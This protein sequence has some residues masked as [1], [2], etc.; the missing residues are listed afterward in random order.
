MIDH[1]FVVYLAKQVEKQNAIEGITYKSIIT[2]SKN[3]DDTCFFQERLNYLDVKTSDAYVIDHRL[4]YQRTL[5][6]Q[7][8]LDQV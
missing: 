8:Y 4:E 3:N 2:Y 5:L 6:W 1:H 7:L